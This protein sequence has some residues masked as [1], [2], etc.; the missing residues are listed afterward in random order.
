MAVVPWFIVWF[1]VAAL[2]NSTGL[3]PAAW[4]GPIGFVATF[5]ISV[6]LAAIG[7][8][9]DL[10]EPARSGARPLALGFVLWVAVALS[11]LAIQHATG[12]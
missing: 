1:L 8:G 9:A 12:L 4:H 6:A 2:I 11:P 3:I 5:L 7:L 10:V